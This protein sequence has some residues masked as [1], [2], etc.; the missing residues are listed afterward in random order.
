MSDN[1]VTNENPYFK[2][3]R[4]HPFI[5]SIASKERWTVSDNHKMPIDMYALL[6]EGKIAGAAT[7]AAP[8]LIS[9]DE[10]N[11][12]L[13]NAA[14]YAFHLNAR[15][16][17]FIVLDVE[18]KCPED[19]KEKLLRTNALYREVS[20][21]G[22]GIHLIFPY[23]AAI[24]A[25]YPKAQNKIVLKHPDGWY[26]ILMEHY[27]TFTARQLPEPD[28]TDATVINEIITDLAKI[29]KESVSVQID[30]EKLDD[31]T[32]PGTDLALDLLRKSLSFYAKTE[33]DFNNDSSRY[34]FGVA[35]YL[36]RKLRDIL[37]TAAIQIAGHEFTEAEKTWLI[38]T[39]LKEH[40]SYRPKHDTQRN[41]L[42]WLFYIANSTIN[43]IELQEDQEKAE[44][45][46]KRKSGKKKAGADA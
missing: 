12:N 36:Y 29:Q 41:G 39:V 22:H 34:E 10:L 7:P 26:E 23:P 11:E 38:A 2:D 42:P 15:E 35:A 16:D 13:A 9:L 4:N 40:L 24:L 3:F 17:N 27:V 45:A 25:K 1:T 5:S 37:R 6:H 46:A 43:K 33:T 19:I 18:P 32:A 8:C 21:S 28:V 30:V 44:K 14:N 20:M 31:V